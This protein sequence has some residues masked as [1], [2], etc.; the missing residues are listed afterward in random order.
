MVL[1]IAYINVDLSFVSSHDELAIFLI[2]PSPEG[3]FTEYI[4]R[5]YLIR[6]SIDYLSQ[7]LILFFKNLSKY[8][9][10]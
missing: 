6:I 2:S 8:T 5:E 7:F 3:S 4:Y 1:R 10:L 9:S